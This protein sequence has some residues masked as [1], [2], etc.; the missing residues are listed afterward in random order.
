MRRRIR[1]AGSLALPALLGLS[2]LAPTTAQAAD[3]T[4]GDYKAVFNYTKPGSTT[5][6]HSI[7]NDLA[8]LVDRAAP[9]STVYMGMYWFGLAELKAKMLEAQ[10]RGVTLRMV[11]EKRNEPSSTPFTAAELKNGSTGRGAPTAASATA[12]TTS[13]PS[14][15]TSTSSSP[16]WTTGGRTWSG[17]ARRTS[18]S[19][20]PAN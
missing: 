15:T 17:R 4:S 3:V 6:D 2:L 14:T 13:T 19:P 8:G 16:P 5:L 10:D 20:S 11:S 9:G 7:L 12:P 1:L 18:P